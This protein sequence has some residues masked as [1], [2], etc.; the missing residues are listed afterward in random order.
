METPSLRPIVVVPAATFAVVASVAVLLTMAGAVAGVRRR[1]GVPI[2]ASTDLAAKAQRGSDSRPRLCP[3]QTTVAT[4]IAVGGVAVLGVRHGRRQVVHEAIVGSEPVDALA[5][6]AERIVLLLGV[7]LVFLVLVV[8]VEIDDVTVLVIDFLVL[9]MCMVVVAN[10]HANVR[11]RPI[12]LRPARR[13][14][15]TRV[16]TLRA[17][18]RPPHRRQRRAQA[19]PVALATLV[20]GV[21]RQRRGG[22]GGC[23]R[24]CGGGVRGRSS[25]S[26]TRGDCR[27]GRFSTVS[28]RPR[29]VMRHHESPAGTLMVAVFRFPHLAARGSFVVVVV[30]RSAAVG[31]PASVQRRRPARRHRWFHT[32]TARDAA[33]AGTA[34][35]TASTS[36]RGV[37]SKRRVGEARLDV[38]AASILLMRCTWFAAVRRAAMCVI[39]C[40]AHPWLVERRP[41][42]QAGVQLVVVV[43]RVERVVIVV[44]VGLV[45]GGRRARQ[46][47]PPHG[48][49]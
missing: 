37:S 21:G 44:G 39:V 35:T 9:L 41:L 20:R 26:G 31:V 12:P 46:R 8:N 11:R 43:R 1:R 24:G 4:F 34:I 15:A 32:G 36:S 38:V 23:G 6:L 2:Q 27:R 47:L 18:N 5:V 30:A 19:Q 33:R 16:A 29:R 13:R 49:R 25:G 17:P 45:T 28:S 40:A 14:T 3:R 42:L 7:F 22:G 48:R 10:A